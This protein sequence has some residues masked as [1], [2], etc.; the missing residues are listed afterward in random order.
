MRFNKTYFLFFVFVNFIFC[1]SS[2][3]QNN[4]LLEEHLKKYD[5]IL[6]QTSTPEQQTENPNITEPPK[7]I[8]EKDELESLLPQ[9][10]PELYSK[11]TLSGSPVIWH[12]GDGPADF[13]PFSKELLTELKTEK[14]LKQSYANAE[15][16]VD[17]LIYKFSD[18]SGAYSTFTLIHRGEP[19]KL[20]VGKNASESESAVSFW[21]GNYFVDIY[22]SSSDS[23]AKEFIVL[24]SQDVSKSIKQEQMPPVVVLQFPALS[25][26]SSSEKYCPGF[27]CSKTFFQDS[28]LDFEILNLPDSGGI[29]QAQFEDEKSK[30]K[31]KIY[32]MLI[33][34]TGNEIAETVFNSLKKFFEDKNRINE[35]PVSDFNFDEKENTFEIRNKESDIYTLIKQKGNL[36]AISYSVKNR[37]AGEK[38]LSLVPWPIEIVKPVK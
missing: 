18:I 12:S 9:L 22:T 25:R 27:V 7:Q 14:I 5:E 34:Y 17:L 35:K 37:K 3:A 6:N 23:T 16:R 24:A 36:L 33:R 13:V 26:V 20:K 4:N 1:L 8:V 28:G 30:G 38:I 21:K 31:E 2:F 11:W 15:H 29:I 32:L 10:I 19:S